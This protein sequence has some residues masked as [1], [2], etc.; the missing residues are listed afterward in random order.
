MNQYLTKRQQQILDYITRQ[1]D[2]T[3][4]APSAQE[5][6]TEF[7]IPSLFRVTRYLNGLEGKGWIVCNSNQAGG[8]T[9]ME[10]VRH[11]RLSVCGDVEE[12]RV[13]FKKRI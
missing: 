11:Y 9:L 5:I 2:H 10:N 12:D 3:G 4:I 13:A 7:E 1:I 8:I 6:A